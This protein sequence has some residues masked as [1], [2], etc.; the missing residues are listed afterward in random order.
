MGD[1]CWWVGRRL[2][3]TC[4]LVSLV[5]GVATGCVEDADLLLQQSLAA[6]LVQNVS[7]VLM[8][9]QKYRKPRTAT[10]KKE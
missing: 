2:H 9:V 4:F 10:W 6:V 7:L 8:F 5:V 3:S 1:H